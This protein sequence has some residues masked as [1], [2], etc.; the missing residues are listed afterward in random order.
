MKTLLLMVMMLTG[1]AMSCCAQLTLEAC[2]QMAKQ[3]Y[4]L[5]KRYDLIHRSAAYN[6][7]NIKKAWLPQVQASVQATVQNRTTQLPDKLSSI[8][9]QSGQTY[10][11]IG[12]EQYRLQVEISQTLWDGGRISRQAEVGKRKAEIEEA[13]TDVNLYALRRRVSDLFFSQLLLDERIR[14]NAQLQ[15]MLQSNEDKLRAML[16]RGVAMQSDVDRLRAERLRAIQAGD[17]LTAARHA[18]SRMLAL[19]CGVEQADSLVKPSS[20]INTDPKTNERPELQLIDCRL[21]LADTQQQ[22]LKSRLLPVLSIFAQGYYGRPG[23]NLFEDMQR[24]R[25]SFNA[26]AGARLSWSLSSLY[27]RR[28]DLH[29]LAVQR[30]EAENAR[31]LFLLNNQMEEAQQQAHIAGRRKVMQADDEIVSLRQSIRRAT[32]AQLTH[33]TIDADRLLQEITKENEA[34]ITRAVHELE[35]LQSIYELKIIKGAF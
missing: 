24:H 16:Q 6:V 1:W 9:A 21:R 29:Q 12:K 32:E 28:N 25:L 13:Q 33:G 30:E 34:C 15:A 35:L 14:L 22:L 27:T 17:E 8:L 31:E 7:S 20:E 19:F 3:N 4:P 10:E 2:Q 18:V 11:G 26:L 23:Y 5:V